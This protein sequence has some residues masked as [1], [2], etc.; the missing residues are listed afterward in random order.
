[1]FIRLYGAACFSL[2]VGY[3]LGYLNLSR[4]KTLIIL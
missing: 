4:A 3:V 1:V 2:G